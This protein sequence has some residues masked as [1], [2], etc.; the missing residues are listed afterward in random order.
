MCSS[1]GAVFAIM[2]ADIPPVLKASWRLWCQEIIQL[3]PFLYSLKHNWRSRLSSTS[4]PAT[5]TS[6]PLKTSIS[7]DSQSSYMATASFIASHT[8]TLNGSSA[9]PPQPY[10]LTKYN[11]SLPLLTLCGASLGVHFGAWVWSISHTSL[12]HSLLWV[13]M[14]P[15]VV[16][17]SSW[18][19][20]LLNYS[21]SPPTFKET[22]GTIIGLL[23]GI[24]ML[25]DVVF[26]TSS[27]STDEVQPTFIGDFVAFI[28]AVAM[29]VYL[30]IGSKVR[31]WC[32][33]WLYSFPVTG[34]AVITT[35]LFS[36][37]FE[38]SS[39]FCLSNACTFGF[40]HPSSL[41]LS[42]YLGG[43]AGVGGH[44]LI[45]YLL[46]YLSPT[47]VATSLLMEPLIGGLLGAALSVQSN[48][49]PFTWCGGVI[50]VLGLVMVILGEKEASSGLK[51]VE[52][53][54][55]SPALSPAP[56]PSPTP[57]LILNVSL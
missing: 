17:V 44:T 56:S 11:Q 36:L 54:P 35:A 21:T 50:L 29:A 38:S 51:F 4:T 41:L 12:A 15:I 14:S 9:I 8:D 32:P 13:S 39:V 33:I 30:S 16:N 48:P 22:A 27:H 49:G 18:I 34:V 25:G 43:G 57:S 23:G 52:R 37:I 31:T 28:G 45:N 53:R 6:I 47:L 5:D 7:A 1:A 10:L 20:Y 2:D 26:A 40:L 42:A 55:F 3:F 46:Q 19:S 24:L